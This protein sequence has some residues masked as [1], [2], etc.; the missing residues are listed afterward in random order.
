MRFSKA[1]GGPV[2][3]LQG[4]VEDGFDSLFKRVLRLG[5]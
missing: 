4:I 2:I 1:V 3:G 5:E